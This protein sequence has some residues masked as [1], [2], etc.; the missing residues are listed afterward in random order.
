MKVQ[1]LR[2]VGFGPFRSAQEID[3][4]RFDDDGLFLIAGRT[5]TGKSSVLDAIAFALYGQVPRYGTASNSSR[6]RSRFCAPDDPT[7]VALEFEHQGRDYRVTRSPSYEV[8]K[9]SGDGIRKLPAKAHLELREGEKWHSIAAQV[10]R[11]AHELL[12]VFPLSAVEFLQVAMLAQNDFMKFLT[13]NSEE[14]QRVLRKLFRTDRY[15]RLKQIAGERAKQANQAVLDA[16]NALETAIDQLRELTA[17]SAATARAQLTDQQLTKLEVVDFDAADQTIAATQYVER[18]QKL[19]DALH[20]ELRDASTMAEREVA[21]AQLTRQIH[22]RQQRYKR[23]VTQR[24]ELE[25]QD[26]EE[27]AQVRTS[28]AAGE[29]AAPLLPGLEAWTRAEHNQEAARDALSMAVTALNTLDTDPDVALD[30]QAPSAESLTA[31]RELAGVLRSRVALDDELVTAKCVADEA[32]VAVEKI[33]RQLATAR[34]RAAQRPAQLEQLRTELATYTQL[35]TLSESRERELER[36]QRVRAA[37]TEL[38]EAQQRSAAASR[39]YLNAVETQQQAGQRERELVQQR[40]SGFAAEL[41]TGLE[42]GEPC[43]VCGSA[44]HPAPAHF[45]SPTVA[46]TDETLAAAQAAAERAAK[47]LSEARDEEN[48]ARIELERLQQT[49]DGKTLVEA[50]TDFAAADSAHRE[51]RAAAAKVPELAEKLA[52]AQQAA[53]ADET[54]LRDLTAAHSRSE[55]EATAAAQRHRQ[56]TLE[57]EQLRAGMPTIAA[58]LERV[59]ALI[60]A[61]ERTVQAREAVVSAVAEVAATAADFAQQLGESPFGDRDAVLE[62]QHTPEQLSAM[63]DRLS[64]HREQ[65]AGV[66]MQLEDESLRELPDQPVDVAAADKAARDCTLRRSQLDRVCGAIDAAST[67]AA[68]LLQQV[69]K[70]DAQLRNRA[71]NADIET[72]FAELLRGQNSRKQSLESFVLRTWLVEVIDAANARL[73]T[74][75]SGRYLLEL[76]ESLEAHG[77]QSGLGIAVFDSYNGERRSPQSLSGGESFLVSLALALALAEVVS[78]QAGG[79]SLDTLFIDEGFGSLDSDTLEVAMR[80]LDQLRQGGRSVGVISHVE[81]MHQRIPAQLRV[82]RGEDGTSRLTIDSIA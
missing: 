64:E 63:R 10:N 2:I 51:A 19:R 49:A 70:H 33:A 47:L 77:S 11:V 75:T 8:P 81:A 29:A 13:A 22:E 53:D 58:R 71:D 40:F 36:C 14:R 38:P 25:L 21:A 54:K 3:F 79:I 27:L 82:M 18:I 69:N 66:L 52:Q 46:V 34:E 80:A 5:G 1:R 59:N 30:A 43:P 48:T 72:R 68:G 4:T 57:V 26:R 32:V 6:L 9:R 28:L 55:A 23:L 78:A 61:A 65:L 45:D 17:D 7:E 20:T 16:K 31:A 35:A 41:A 15:E 37:A 42:P 60:A 56:L 74:L 44:E 39:A 67:R 50:E 73:A 12:Q 76:D 24:T 62:A